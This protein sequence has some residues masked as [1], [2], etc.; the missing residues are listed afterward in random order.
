MAQQKTIEL[1]VDATQA[2]QALEKFGGTLEDVYSEGAQPLNFAIGELED[3]LYEMAAAGDTSSREFREM[4]EEVARMKKVIIETDMTIDGMSQTMSQKVGGSIG[5]LT[6]G[7]ELSMGAMGAFGVESEKVEEALLRVQSAMAISQGF[8]G[9]KEAIPSFKG[10]AASVKMYSKNVLRSVKAMGAFKTALIATGIGAF[11]VLLGHLIA[12]WDKY[13][14]MLEDFA[15]TMVK[16][17]VPAQEEHIEKVRETRKLAREELKD[18]DKRLKALEKN[19]EKQKTASSI[20]KQKFE[21]AIRLATAEGKSKEE[22]EKIERKKLKTIIKS[23][24]TELKLQKQKMFALRDEIKAKATLG[25]LSQEELDE[26]LKGLRTQIET[27]KQTYQDLE[28]A[29]TDLKVFEAEI[30]TEK[31]ERWKESADKA[32]ELEKE[33]NEKLKALQEEAR[34]NELEQERRKNEILDEIAQA[35]YEALTSAQDMEV[36][37]VR[38]KYFRLI[39]EAKL[40]GQETAILEK[41]QSDQIAAINDKYRLEEKAKK[42]AADQEKKDKDAQKLADEQEF[43]DKQFQ[44]ASDALSGISDLVNGFAGEGEEA[45]KRAFN[46]NK[47]ISIAQAIISTAQAITAQLAVPQDALTGANFVKAGIVAAT[48]AAQIATIS[49]TKFNGGSSSS[50]SSGSISSGS[51]PAQ[52][53]PATFNVV[54]NTGSNQLAETLGSSP[55]QAFV[56]AGDVTTAQSLERNKIQQSTL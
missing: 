39:E 22:I 2:Q 23:A 41:E 21:N 31:R 43:R 25:E 15:L 55:I 4:S 3:R 13:T 7:F 48:G 53:Q 6:A 40:Y 36:N 47:A 14:K 10:L 18:A 32:V 35:E 30:E 5:G 51:A 24:E 38:D 27:T 28:N 29:R 9:I 44:M 33:K 37:A 49:R 8:Q 42:D 52:S 12:N 46:V 1:N 56:V 54:G 20:E 50:I 45:Q 19:I 17:V 11:V 26:A 34:Q 16:K